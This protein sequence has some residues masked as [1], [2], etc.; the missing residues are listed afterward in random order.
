MHPVVA[1]RPFAPEARPLGWSPPSQNCMR[2]WRFSSLSPTAALLLGVLISVLVATGLFGV[3]LGLFA[4]GEEYRVERILEAPSG[5]HRAVLYTGMGGGAAGW[6]AQRLLVEPTA[7]PEPTTERVSDASSE[8]V[9]SASCSS[10]VTLRW[11]G[12]SHLRIVYTIGAAGVSLYQRS[13]SPDGRVR[14]SYS[15]ASH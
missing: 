9:F 11:Q 6:C 8:M 5:K 2:E 14:L 10:E 3:F 4:G 1:H 7:A 12:A 13:D 15:V